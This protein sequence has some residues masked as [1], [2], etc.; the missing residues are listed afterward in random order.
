MKKAWITLL[1]LCL[2]FVAAATGCQPKEPASSDTES[3]AESAD[4][5]AP[6]SQTTDEDSAADPADP[7]DGSAPESQAGSTTAVT[8]KPGATTTKKPGGGKSDVKPIK[9]LKGYDF[10][11]AWSTSDG[12]EMEYGLSDYMDAFLDSI[13]YVE[14]AYNCK[15]T[16]IPYDYLGIYDTARA[17]IMSNEKFADVIL[18]T[19]YTS[20]KLYLNGL[21]TPA[22]SVSGLNLK[23]DVWVKEVSDSST[24][25]D[26][27]WF[28]Q[29]NALHPAQTGAMIHYNKTL[30]KKLKLEDP[31]DLV[32]K[33]EWTWAKFASMLK[34]ARADLN[35]DGKYTESDR[36][37]AAT[38]SYDGLYPFFFSTGTKV[39]S[40][41]ANKKMTYNLNNEQALTRCL[42][43]YDLMKENGCLYRSTDAKANEKMYFGGK[44]LFYLAQASS[45]RGFDDFDGEDAIVPHPEYKKGSGYVSGVDHNYMMYSFPRNLSNKT[46][47]GT[48]FQALAET[49]RKN[50]TYDKYIEGSVK[51]TFAN[52]SST[53]MLKKY[54]APRM[55]IDPMCYF[56]SFDLSIYNG[57]VCA[58]CNAFYTSGAQTAAD[59]VG[60]YADAIQ[61]ILDDMMNS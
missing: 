55:Y 7:T 18:S 21:L 52:S 56:Y 46:A 44:A 27:T 2:L 54:I 34:A 48:I 49:C 47:T 26:G 5:Q 17:Q 42:E 16:V 32:K 36:F 24:F 4:S 39:I 23:S 3:V 11:I 35:N 43:F 38:A 53:E 13:A 8:K 41:D 57:T 10:V 30:L 50:G 15:I 51:P 14:K 1:I 22:S 6:D 60:G 33:G 20:S 58:L 61:S 25:K 40:L 31:A 37:G 59:M 9:D 45:G 12:I 19:M 28:V 29:S